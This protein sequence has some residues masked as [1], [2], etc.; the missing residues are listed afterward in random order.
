MKGKEGGGG[1]VL[2]RTGVVLCKVLNAMGPFLQ[3]NRD[4]QLR[5]DCSTFGATRRI[6][7]W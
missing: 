3:S 5:I 4:E 2:F 6:C 7:I 1:G